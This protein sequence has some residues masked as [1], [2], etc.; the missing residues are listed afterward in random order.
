MIVPSLTDAQILRS[1][2]DLVRH[3]RESQIEGVADFFVG[4]E[5]LLLSFV[6][7]QAGAPD[8]LLGELEAC[9]DL[10]NQGGNVMGNST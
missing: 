5:N 3:V 2:D 6:V 1:V 8:E 10:M 7:L 4:D 9:V